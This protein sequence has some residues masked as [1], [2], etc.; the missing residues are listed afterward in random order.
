MLR[1]T[2]YA[3][4]SAGQ[5]RLV[6]RYV[7]TNVR[8]RDGLPMWSSVVL[9]ES[10]WKQLRIVSPEVIY[11][12]GGFL[13]ADSVMIELLKEKAAHAPRGRCRLC[14]H[15]DPNAV[16]QE[17]LIVMNRDTYVRPHR[18]L[19]KTEALTII[20]GYGDAILFDESGGI[21]QVVP[22]SPASAGGCFFYR[23]PADIFHTL[24]FRS[25]WLVFLETTIGPFDRASTEA[26]NWAPP[27]TDVA[28]GCAYLA[29]LKLPVE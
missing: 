20:E 21:N 11:S 26:A 3:N 24:L 16:Q 9:A 28:A 14:F 12:N 27:E 15:A 29:G 19:R 2:R 23:M 10:I 6:G 18:H 17:M 8:P 5:S 4:Y 22:M 13:T 25:E 7:M 1:P